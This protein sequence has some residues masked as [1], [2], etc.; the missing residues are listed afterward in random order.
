MT[1]K[2]TARFQLGKAGLTD[3]FIEA[4]RKTFKNRKIVKISLLKTFSRDRKE[5]KETAD[6]ICSELRDIGTFKYR[7]VGF[8]II[9]L[10]WKKQACMT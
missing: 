7:I 2:G 10:K 6:R 4:L 8:T 9:L 5:V 3:D 1:E